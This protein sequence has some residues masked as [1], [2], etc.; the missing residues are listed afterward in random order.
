MLQCIIFTCLIYSSGKC[1]IFCYLVYF[2]G[3]AMLGKQSGKGSRQSVPD[4][5]FNLKFRSIALFLLALQV[6]T[7]KKKRTERK[8]DMRYS[9]FQRSGGDLTAL[10]GEALLF[11]DGATKRLLKLFEPFD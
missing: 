4:W 10:H 7:R 3:R 6:R 1:G 8:H 11:G 9:C 5:K 2:S